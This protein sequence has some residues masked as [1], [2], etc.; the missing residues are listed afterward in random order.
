MVKKRVRHSDMVN[1]DGKYLRRQINK[2]SYDISQLSIKVGYGSG[3]SLRRAIEKGR[4]SKTQL[5][6]LSTLLKFDAEKAI[7]SDHKE[8]PEAISIQDQI[9]IVAKMQEEI[10]HI[11]LDI[12]KKMDDIREK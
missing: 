12:Y 3:K 2:S 8:E 7:K 1:V 4:M 10:T 6:H 9:D 5:F 11:L